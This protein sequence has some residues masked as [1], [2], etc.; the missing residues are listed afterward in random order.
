MRVCAVAC[1]IGCVHNAEHTNQQASTMTTIPITTENGKT[2]LEVT[3]FP[4]CAVCGNR[5]LYQTPKHAAQRQTLPSA[6]HQRRRT[7]HTTQP[8]IAA[9]R[10]ALPAAHL[11]R[12]PTQHRHHPLHRT[13]TRTRNLRRLH[14]TRHA[15]TQNRS[16]RLARKNQSA[17]IPNQRRRHLDQRSCT[18]ALSPSLQKHS[19][20]TQNR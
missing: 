10:F 13:T 2:A 16:I 14:P 11:A 17:H 9:N 7:P 4:A 1:L 20:S 8:A 5:S 3:A 18:H 15:Y 12:Q 19:H 6:R